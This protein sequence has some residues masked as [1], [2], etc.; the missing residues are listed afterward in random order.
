MIERRVFQLLCAALVLAVLASWWRDAD[1]PKACQLWWRDVPC[2]AAAEARYHADG[3]AALR[4]AFEAGTYSY[5]EAR[6]MG[7]RDAEG[8]TM[9]DSLRR[10]GGM[11]QGQEV[12]P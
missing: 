5:L 9:Y 3:Q 8:E 10:A 6:E 7:L 4:A 2:Y 11:G 12:T 1:S